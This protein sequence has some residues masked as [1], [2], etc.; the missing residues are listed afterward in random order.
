MSMRV[1]LLAKALS[2][3]RELR[4][5]ES[6]TRLDLLAH[7]ERS[8]AALRSFA[9]E[10]SPFYRRL[11]QGQGAAP[12]SELSV[13][14]K[15]TLMEYFDE[16]VTDRGIRLQDVRSFLPRMA[17]GQ[18]FRGTYY[19]SATSAPLDSPGCSSGMSM[20]GPEFW[21]RTAARTRGAGWTLA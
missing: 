3:H 9:F 15:A 11:H 20:S 2:R 21:P 4:R 16:L 6:W 5:R 1:S 14:T 17:T 12:L 18:L 10:A 19:V 8:Q 13:L 7:Q